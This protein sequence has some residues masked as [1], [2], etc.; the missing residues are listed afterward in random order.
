MALRVRALCVMILCGALVSEY[1]PVFAHPGGTDAQGGHHDRRTGTY[2]FHSKPSAPV[3]R[4]VA[5]TTFRESPRVEAR[6]RPPTFRSS[7]DVDGALASPSSVAPRSEGQLLDYG[8]IDKRTDGVRLA[9]RIR[10]IPH[11]GYTPQESDL[12][13]IFAECSAD[14]AAIALFYFSEMDL[15]RSA[16]ATATREKRGSPKVRFFPDRDPQKRQP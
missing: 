10:L 14:D 8:I 15:K 1:A 11:R 9:L 4:P 3:E 5:R 16:W 12:I 7:K 13:R 6:T 2:H